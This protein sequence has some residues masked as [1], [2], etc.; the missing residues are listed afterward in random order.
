[1][2]VEAASGFSNKKKLSLK[3]VFMRIIIF[4][5]IPTMPYGDRQGSDD[6]EFCF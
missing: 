4:S 3:F 6:L 1:M 2:T 5:F